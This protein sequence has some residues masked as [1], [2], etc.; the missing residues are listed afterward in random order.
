MNHL[1]LNLQLLK[2]D[3]K[4]VFILYNK[5]RLQLHRRSLD[6]ILGSHYVALWKSFDME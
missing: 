3:K 1:I 4:I 2:I 5:T 6:I